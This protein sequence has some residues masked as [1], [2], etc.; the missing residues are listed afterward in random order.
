[1]NLDE[2][3]VKIQDQIARQAE[4]RVF[5]R[6]GSLSL[7]DNNQNPA[8]SSTRVAK[9]AERVLNAKTFIQPQKDKAKSLKDR[10]IAAQ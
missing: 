7:F 9:F 6:K 1:K 10:T 3:I 8:K 4:L 5:V 2:Q